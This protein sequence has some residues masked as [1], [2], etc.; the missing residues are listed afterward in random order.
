MDKWS[1]PGQI[2][3][4]WIG[5]R[6]PAC[7]FTHVD[8]SGRGKSHHLSFSYIRTVQ[9]RN[10][11]IPCLAMIGVG[12]AIASSK[13]LTCVANFAPNLSLPQTSVH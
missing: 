7:S 12:E 5:W 4:F 6:E 3:P 9:N 10:S 1:F 13:T 11:I 2:P 8:R